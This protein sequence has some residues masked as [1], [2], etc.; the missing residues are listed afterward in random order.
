MVTD[1]RL[2][3]Q[4]P[5]PPAQ[6]GDRHGLV[7]VG[8]VDQHRRNAG[9]LDLVAVHDA[10]RDAAGD[11]GVDRVAAGAQDRMRRFGGEILAG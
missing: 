6:A 10:E 5:G 9:E 4:R 3:V 7:A 2:D 8:Q 1:E 11:T